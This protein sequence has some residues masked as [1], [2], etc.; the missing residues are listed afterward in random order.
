MTLR[1]KFITA[2]AT[3]AGIAGTVG[4]CILV[5]KLDISLGVP[6]ALPFMVA[7]VAGSGLIS[8]TIGGI[9]AQTITNFIAPPKPA[10]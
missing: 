9:S 8:A 6:G 5:S 1:E 7:A 4:S 10:A 2:A 3:V